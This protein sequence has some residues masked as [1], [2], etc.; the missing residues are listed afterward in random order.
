MGD[1][2]GN[3]CEFKS[4]LA[5]DLRI[6]KEFF[7]EI[8]RAGNQINIIL[9]GN[10]YDLKR[11]IELLKE[12]LYEVVKKGGEID[13][14]PST[15]TKIFYPEPAGAA[16]PPP[17]APGPEKKKRNWSDEVRRAAGERMKKYHEENRRRK[18]QQKD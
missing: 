17:A 13:S 18:E 1:L 6:L 11:E 16:L 9:I 8:P 12:A 7:G 2:I 3:A 10:T 14:P 5:D 4:S 15:A